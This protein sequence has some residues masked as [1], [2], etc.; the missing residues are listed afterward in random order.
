MEYADLEMT[1]D[2]DASTRSADGITVRAGDGR[3]LRLEQA[4]LGRGT[5]GVV[6]PVAG[7][8]RV[9]AK[10]YREWWTQAPRQQREL[11]TRKLAEMAAVDVPFAGDD[12]VVAW[13]QDTVALGDERPVD[14]YLMV[15]APEDAVPLSILGRTRFG[16]DAAKLAANLLESAVH[17]LHRQGLVLGDVNAVN[18]ALDDRGRLWF[19]DV[20]GWQF[21]ARD[22]FLHYAHGATDYYTHQSI[23]ARLSG[24]LPNCCDP[25]CP[26][27]GHP[28]TPTPSCRPREPYHDRFGVAQLVRDLTGKRR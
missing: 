7:D 12:V 23:F 15:R 27:T 10:M 2:T 5:Y 4:R 19:Y 22:G 16:S 25:R 8:D 18:C 1:P 14:G 17:E 21:R 11:R 9:A 28:H 20:D 26:L 6:H 3:T 24:T 13:P